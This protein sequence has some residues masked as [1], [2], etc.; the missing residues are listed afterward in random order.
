ML[1]SLE[2]KITRNS[3]L[4]LVTLNKII[5]TSGRTQP[6]NKNLNQHNAFNSKYVHTQKE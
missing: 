3:I 2:D 1:S 5:M 6:D 4:E